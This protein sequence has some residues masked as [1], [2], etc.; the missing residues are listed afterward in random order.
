MDTG[1]WLLVQSH[2]DTVPISRLLHFTISKSSF[3]FLKP[4]SA[5][6]K[7]DPKT[8]VTWHLPAYYKRDFKH[9]RI[10][11][12]KTYVFRYLET[13]HP[14]GLKLR[15][16]Q[17]GYITVHWRSDLGCPSSCPGMWRE[18]MAEKSNLLILP[19]YFCWE[20]SILKLLRT[21]SHQSTN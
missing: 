3:Y 21:I 10:P 9:L 20:I 13:R 15:L 1:E 11:S 16:H 7:T 2:F 14:S 19:Y 5:L 8:S 18:D 12:L 17:M 6:K 4:F